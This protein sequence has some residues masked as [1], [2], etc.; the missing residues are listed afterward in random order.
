MNRFVKGVILLSVAAFIAECIEFLVNM[1]LAREL[2]EH[3]MG[4]YMSILPIIMLVL[5]IASLELPV[6]IS[7]FIAESHERLHK[8]MLR[9][10]FK[11]TLVVTSTTTAIAAIV[12]PFIPV[13]QSYHPLMKGLVLSLI[14]IIAFTS[15]ARG[16]FMG[17]QQMGRI[18]LANMLKKTIQLICLFLF[19][20]WY[21]FDIETAVLIAI[22]VI[23]ASDLVVFIYLYSQYVMAK[24][25]VNVRSVELRGSDVRKRLLAVSI[26]TT[27][28]RIFHAIANAVEP[29]LIKGAL[30]AAGISGTLAVDH[31]GMLAGVAMSIG[32]FPA[33]IA[34]S[35]MI[36]MIPSVSEA[37]AL[38]QYDLVKKRVRQ[39]ILITFGYGVPAVMVMYYFAYPL[40]QLFFDS[41]QAAVYLQLLWPYFL[42][43]LF[44]MPFQACL[45]G[46]GLIKDVFLHNIWVHVV[47]FSMVYFL[48]SMESLNMMGVILGMNTGMLLLTAL[49]YATICKELGVSMFLTLK[50]A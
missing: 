19:F 21:S 29:F 36:V 34:H 48:G 30:V 23:V 6:S 33:F 39:A 49:H 38:G 26:P 50:K 16:Y 46:M 4:L 20:H 40:T 28:M 22:G 24:N 32:F 47:S 14:P 2:G 15:I 42:C 43:H 12:L 27:G 37:Y 3:G 35:I 1:I 17:K 25:A 10:A 45:I 18:A 7:K 31:Y 13:F 41:P 8:S 9:H 11:M 5:V 44:V